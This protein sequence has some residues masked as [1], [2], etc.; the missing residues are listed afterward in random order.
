MTVS[1]TFTFHADANVPDQACL[2][3]SGPAEP[4]VYSES[5]SGAMR[6]QDLHEPDDRFTHYVQQD[7]V[8]FPSAQ[9]AGAFLTASTQSWPACANRQYTEINSGQP[10]K[11]WTVGP[12][13]NTNGTL[14]ATQT[15]GGSGRVGCLVSGR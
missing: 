9:D 8:L 3:V 1:G 11:V 12:V 5:F 2:P 10:D 14:S 6:A 13:S 15:N 4:T 7:V